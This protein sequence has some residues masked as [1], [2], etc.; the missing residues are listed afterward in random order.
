MLVALTQ[1]PTK[2]GTDFH[3]IVLI[4]A[5]FVLYVFNNVA[6][7]SNFSGRAAAFFLRRFSHYCAYPCHVCVICVFYIAQCGC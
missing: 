3:I 4:S 1:I 6:G 5:M 2:L 7:V